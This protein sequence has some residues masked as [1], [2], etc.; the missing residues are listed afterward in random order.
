MRSILRSQR[1]TIMAN[2]QEIEETYNFIAPVFIRF[3]L[4]QAEKRVRGF[5]VA[6]NGLMVSSL[7]AVSLVPREIVRVVG[8]MSIPSL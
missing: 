7:N 3:L 5:D 4:W 8:V 1:G 2:R 6:H